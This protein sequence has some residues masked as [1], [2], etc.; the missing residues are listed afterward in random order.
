[1]LKN[2]YR[3]GLIFL[4]LIVALFWPFF[5]KG[6]HPFP[7]NLLLGW[8]EPWRSNYF[9]NGK[10]I[11]PNK[12]VVDDAF[13][14]IYP[15]RILS[16]DMF[17]KFEFPLWNP[18]NGAGMPLL[19][20]MN[21]GNL[22][23]FNILFFILPY[24]FAW[25]IYVIL[26]PL[27]AG[28]CMYIYCRK[29]TLSKS[30]SLFAS[31][32][33]MFSG[34]VTVKSIFSIYGLAIASLPLFL[35]LIES[36]LQNGF[37]KRVYLIP[38]LIFAMLVSALP[39]ISLYILVI[40]FIYFLFRLNQIKNKFNIKIKQLLLFISLL[41]LG[42][43]ISSLQL[44]P[45]LELF[46]HAS[47]NTQ[48]SAFIID[49]FLVPI[50]HLVSILIPN[51]FGNEALYNYWG[52]A[53]Y[54]Q[55]VVSLGLIP[56]FFAVLGIGKKKKV[57]VYLFFIIAA[58][59]TAALAIDWIGSRLFF[60][61][62]IPIVST[63]A[64]TRV[65]FITTFAICVLAGF[66][67]ENFLSQK[68]LSKLFL[69]KS[70]LLIAL[71][72]TVFIF[73]FLNF[74]NNLPCRFGVVTNC[75]IVALRNT[76]LEASIFSIALIPFFL[77]LF[78]KKNWKVKKIALISILVILVTIGTY[79]ANKFF[80]YSSISTFFPNHPITEALKEKAKYNRVFG[81]GEATITPNIPTQL[82]IYDPQYFHPLYILR[83]REL[84]EY[85]N[86]G[87]FIPNLPRGE[88]H[89]RSE[90]TSNPQLLERR[91][92]LLNLLSISHLIFK[93]EEIKKH[94][95]IVWENNKSYII[96]NRNAL[97]RAYLAKKIEVIKPQEK[98]L[99]TLFD[100]KFDINSTVILEENPSPIFSSNQIKNSAN[101]DK[102]SENYVNLNINSSSNS[103]LVL[104]DNYYPGWKAYIDN[105]ETK[106][107][108]ANY[109]FRAIPVPSGKHAV[110]FRYQPKSF[111]TGIIISIITLFILGLIFLLQ[112]K[113]YTK[114]L[115]NQKRH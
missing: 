46:S 60:S 40:I 15:L 17:K 28:V 74:H 5:F 109:T 1:M 80:P 11:L 51:Y 94:G 83:Y 69:L 52:T 58:T 45:T 91:E 57:N 62:P 114:F 49:K 18:Y 43:G 65:F 99:E 16:I 12:P 53:D 61:L 70:I 82:R 113:S 89:I 44:L 71:I 108:R 104:T 100:P 8:H 63:A 78:F 37:T 35:Y 98:I 39:Q 23:P 6:L 56:C 13:K 64:P 75:R 86:N 81:I 67:F 42:F 30:S 68:K 9:V 36:Y 112:S 29:I 88:A 19:A 66:G 106:I 77:Y 95:K 25:S 38:I 115:T 41:L 79:N 20:G 105:K 111:Y 107:Y 54:E 31:I 93:K 33:F 47:V 85:A 96:E 4:L 48:G 73:T 59:T 87:K 97:P 76:I 103:M 50:Q 7:G 32:S 27:L 14:H 3:I 101:I 2:N 22:D 24:P 10:I 92:R 55:T 84:L 21:N 110:I 90:A 102:Y 34:L 72:S 26:Q